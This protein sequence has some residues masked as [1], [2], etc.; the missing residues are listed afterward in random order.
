MKLGHNK[1]FADSSEI[2][3]RPIRYVATGRGFAL[4]C[5]TSGPT[6]Q[7]SSVLCRKYREWQCGV[8]LFAVGN[9]LNFVSFGTLLG[10]KLQSYCYSL[11]L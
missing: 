6:N 2:T 8:G 3:R 1:R 5:P 10:L 11:M 9:V 4:K 7:S